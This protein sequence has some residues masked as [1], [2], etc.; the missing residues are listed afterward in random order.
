LSLEDGDLLSEGKNFEG[1]V[2]STADEDAHY[3]KNRSNEF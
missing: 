1:C 2:G 3:G